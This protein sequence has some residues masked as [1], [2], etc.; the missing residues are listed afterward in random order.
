[1]KKMESFSPALFYS[2]QSVWNIMCCLHVLGGTFKT[3]LVQKRESWMVRDLRAMLDVAEFMKLKPDNSLK[4]ESVIIWKWIKLISCD[5]RE[6]IQVQRI[7]AA[8]IRIQISSNRGKYFL[9]ILIKIEWVAPGVSIFS[10]SENVQRKSDKK[11]IENIWRGFCKRCK[12]D[13]LHRWSLLKFLLISDFNN[14]TKNLRCN[15]CLQGSREKW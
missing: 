15:S 12:I 9:I 11:L 5:F 6:P 4:T 1:M 10:I 8:P 2:V 13:F 7:L 14:S 3:P